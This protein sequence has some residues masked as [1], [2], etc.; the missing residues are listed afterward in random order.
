MIAATFTGTDYEMFGAKQTLFHSNMLKAKLSDKI[1]TKIEN[2]AH[3][4]IHTPNFILLVL[5]ILTFLYIRHLY[6][7]F[8]CH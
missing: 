7:L 1:I 5:S 2:W 8:Y 4:Y 6:V 3:S